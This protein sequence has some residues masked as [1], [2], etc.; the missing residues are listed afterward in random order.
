[1]SLT[2]NLQ[3]HSAAFYNIVPPLILRTRYPVPTREQI[4]RNIFWWGMLGGCALCRSVLR[5]S[6]NDQVQM[7]TY[8][9]DG[10]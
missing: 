4:Q 7:G 8:A 5:H 10:T 2:I 3:I 9:N 6:V 1:M